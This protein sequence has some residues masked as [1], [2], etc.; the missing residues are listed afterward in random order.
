ML[1]NRASLR[2][3]EKMKPKTCKLLVNTILAL[4]NHCYIGL[5]KTMTV[6]WE[7]FVALQPLFLRYSVATR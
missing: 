4:A 3:V 5:S 1:E 2:F 7:Y 6:E